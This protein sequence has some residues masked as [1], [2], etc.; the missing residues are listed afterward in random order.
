M[1]RIMIV[2]DNEMMRRYLGLKLMRAGHS[3]TRV[4]ERGVAMTILNECEQDILITSVSSSDV[5]GITFAHDARAL[6]D[7][8]QVIFL[9]GFSMIPLIAE[10][11]EGAIARLGAPQ[12]INTLVSEVGRLTKAA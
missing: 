2:S 3:I 1:A 6:D 8:M 5:A 7:Q 10:E 9:A 12:H 11:D 4:A